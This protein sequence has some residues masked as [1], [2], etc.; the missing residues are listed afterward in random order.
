MNQII[1]VLHQDIPD[2]RLYL[3]IG[4][5]IFAGRIGSKLAS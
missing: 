4:P 5:L 3:H 2:F 1:W